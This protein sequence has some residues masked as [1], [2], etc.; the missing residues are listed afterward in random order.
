MK[1]KSRLIPLAIIAGLLGT[2]VVHPVYSAP[3]TFNTALP[4]AKGQFIWRE[5]LVFRNRS[6]NGPRQRDVTISALSSVLGYGVTPR[7]SIFAVQPYFFGKD[8]DV[9]TPSGRVTRRTEGLGDTT[10]FG[11]LTVSQRDFSGGTLRASAFAGL[12]APTGR[13]DDRDA[14]GELPR[15]L[16]AGDGAWDG[17]A[18]L[19]GTLQTLRAQVDAQVAYRDNGR[20]DGFERGSEAR[21][22]A[23]L[24]L[25][26][27]PLNL[28]GL[29]GT[30]GFTYLLL[31]S[32]LSHVERNV[33]GGSSDPDS[34]GVQWLLAPGLQ[35]ISR[36]W[37]LEGTVQLPVVTNE[38]GDAIRD[39]NIVRVGFRHNF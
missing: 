8:L 4:V 17:F 36:R 30:P 13:H 37:L 15:P 25:R 39:D 22:D 1:I 26:V 10:A 38:N 3:N 16:Q 28:D 11:K 7:F 12:S 19:V 32:N 5:Q 18:G 27:L 34:G 14:L 24:Q 33:A 2:L 20:H 23:A 21:L 29:S 9:T 6:D 31:E 35:Y